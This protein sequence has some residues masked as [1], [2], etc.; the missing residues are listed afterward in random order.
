MASTTPTK[1]PHFTDPSLKEGSPDP[2]AVP[3]AAQSNGDQP[4]RTSFSFLRRV[5]LSCTLRLRAAHH[6]LT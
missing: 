4:R 5:R 6:I 3:S 1:P 2:A